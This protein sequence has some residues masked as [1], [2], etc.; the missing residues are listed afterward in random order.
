MDHLF[1]TQ[2][3]RSN[4]MSNSYTSSMR[5]ANIRVNLLR[6]SHFVS[7]NQKIRFRGAKASARDCLRVASSGPPTA[8]AAS[9]GSA[10]LTHLPAE[11]SLAR[12]KSATQHTWVNATRYSIKINTTVLKILIDIHYLRQAGKCGLRLFFV[13]CSHCSTICKTTF[14]SETFFLFGGSLIGTFCI[15]VS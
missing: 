2:R 14:A 5:D 13:C 8:R 10:T 12:A 7:Y 15:H 9:R 3:Y 6:L 11:A 1:A 4:W